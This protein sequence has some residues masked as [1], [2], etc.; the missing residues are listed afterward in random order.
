MREETMGNDVTLLLDEEFFQELHRQLTRIK[1][2]KKEPGDDRTYVRI[3]MWLFKQ[4]SL[5]PAVQVD[6]DGVQIDQAARRVDEAIEE[7]ANVG[8][9]VQIV[10]WKGAN[11]FFEIPHH[12]VN[13]VH[14]VTSAVVDKDFRLDPGFARKIGGSRVFGDKLSRW[15][16]K[17]PNV[18]VY[19]EPYNVRRAKTLGYGFSNHQKFCVFSHRG[20]LE[21]IVGGFNINDTYSAKPDHSLPNE[22]W[23]DTAVKIVGPAARTVENEWLRRWNKQFWF[24]PEPELPAIAPSFFAIATKSNLSKI[25]IATTNAESPRRAAEYDIRDLLVERIK[26]ANNYIFLEN[27]ALTDPTLISELSRR[28]TEVSDLKIIVLVTHTRNPFYRTDKDWAAMEWYAY[29]HLAIPRFKT[30]KIVKNTETIDLKKG[31]D[32]FVSVN[33]STFTWRN[34]GNVESCALR[35][36]ADLHVDVPVMYGPITTDSNGGTGPPSVAE[37]KP[38]WPYVHSKLALIDDKYA[39]IG[40]SNWTSRSMIY[41]GEISAMIEN[42]DVV[43]SMRERLFS[44]WEE[45]LTPENWATQA[46]SNKKNAKN[47]KKDKCYIM[48]LQFSDFVHP[49]KTE[50]QTWATTLATS[51]IW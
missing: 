41:D 34:S 43:G 33:A 44:H 4:T 51:D 10:V 32:S 23:H 42:T 9:R 6:V 20:K 29:V 31:D 30:V 50:W 15:A 18:D 36:I 1:G 40:S 24:H 45:G 11:L 46:T 25:T 12:L 49:D 5:L 35:E 38:Q 8:H 16:E 19:L 47:L 27:Y 22:R 21:A 26:E 13:A 28:A 7:I 39:F 37:K 2:I 14:W 17:K 48:P 3:G